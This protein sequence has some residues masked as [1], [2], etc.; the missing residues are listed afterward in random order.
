[1]QTNIALENRFSLLAGILRGPLHLAINTLVD[2]SPGSSMDKL[3]GITERQVRGDIVAINR[4]EFCDPD[5]L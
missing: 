5:P 1:M 2:T 4:R 3:L